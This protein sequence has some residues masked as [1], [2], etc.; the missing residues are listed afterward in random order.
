M[1]LYR[2]ITVD[3][4]DT[5]ETGYEPAGWAAFCFDKW[6]E[7][8]PFYLPTDQKVFRS[9]SGAQAR[10]DLIN[11]WGGVA[12]LTEAEPQW[13]PVAK[14]NAK[15]AQGR[16]VARIERLRAQLAEAEAAALS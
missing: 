12:I 10:V 9:R 4:P 14:A 6:G 5:D 13:T 7:R 3:G 8:R 11:R 2:A 16:K 15:R 1:R